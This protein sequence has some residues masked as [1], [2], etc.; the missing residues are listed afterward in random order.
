MSTSR[1]EPSRL[2]KSSDRSAEC[3]TSVSPS[4]GPS[5]D[6]PKSPNLSRQPGSA[7]RLSRPALELTQVHYPSRTAGL[8]RRPPGLGYAATW[9]RSYSPTCG[10]PSVEPRKRGEP[11]RLN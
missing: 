7:F 1:F 6:Q 3:R 10:R 4:E 5:R 9:V 11:L 2:R 8:R